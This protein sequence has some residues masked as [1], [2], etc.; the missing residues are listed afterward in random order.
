MRYRAAFD[1]S[2]RSG[3]CHKRRIGQINSLVLKYW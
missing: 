2:R 1:G 3:Y